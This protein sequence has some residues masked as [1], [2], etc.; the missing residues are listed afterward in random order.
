MKIIN[1]F[2]QVVMSMTL[3]LFSV[4]CG[5]NNSKLV[6]KEF[7]EQFTGVDKIEIEGSFIEVF[8]QGSDGMEEVNLSAF[9]EFQENTGLDIKYKQEGSV[10]K[11]EVERNDTFGFHFNTKS[12]GFLS[13]KGPKN[14]NL[15]IESSSGIIDVQSV[16]NENINLSVN[17]GK[18][19]VQDIVVNNINLKASSGKIEGKSLSGNLECKINSG[20]LNLID[21]SGNIQA[22]A[23]SGSLHFDNVN[24]LLNAKVSSGS[25]KMNGIKM[26][27]K[28]EVSSGSAKI[29]DSGLID[30]SYFQANS[31]SIS[32]QTFSDLKNYNFD[33]RANSGNVSLGDQKSS[34]EMIIRNS[35]STSKIYGKVNSGNLKIY[36]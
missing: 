3:L 12:E 6:T 2:P 15:V 5:F 31:G 30:E 11:I 20:S 28:I 7:E 24:G 1:K 25:L 26:V 35:D 13:L 4:S 19:D 10:L 29:T 22:S 36:N 14:M 33:L 16:E 8:Y 17:S 18:I 34:S 32:I 27:G 23:S 9:L 21:I